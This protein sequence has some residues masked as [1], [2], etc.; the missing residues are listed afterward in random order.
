L[1]RKY[2]NVQGSIYFSSKSFNNNP[3]GWCDSLRNNYYKEPALLPAMNWLP[4]NP[5]QNISLS[6]SQPANIS[7]KEKQNGTGKGMK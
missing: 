6:S 1:L 2:P 7:N 3:N 4:K 5:K